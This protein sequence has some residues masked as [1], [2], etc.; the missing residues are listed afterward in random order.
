MNENLDTLNDIVNQIPE[1]TKA[2][3]LDHVSTTNFPNGDI[4]V[5]GEGWEIKSFSKTD[6]IMDSKSYIRFVKSVEKVIRSSD[7]YSEYI[8]FLKSD[9]SINACAVLG[10]IN[11][12]L[13]PIEMHHYPFTLYDITSIVLDSVIDQPAN[14]I[15]TFAI[16][17]MVMKL[18]FEHKIGIVPLSV[19][20][21]ELAHAGEI[22]IDIR[23][24]F[25]RL[26]HF[27]VQFKDFIPEEQFEK[28]KKLV[29]M[30]KADQVAEVN[31]GLLDYNEH[32][33]KFKIKLDTTFL[34]IL[35]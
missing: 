28:V 7:E 12:E 10:N 8:G 20:I 17:D 26:D 4:E 6:Q 21:H 34:S 32:S 29:E 13:V 18:H 15:T 35:Q 14:C 25:G 22:F 19:T 11:T 33:S 30:S 23:Q 24:V 3:G 1:E 5:E 27:L 9:L 2:S 31:N 16:A